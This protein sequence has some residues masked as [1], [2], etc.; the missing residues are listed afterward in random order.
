VYINAELIMEGNMKCSDFYSNCRRSLSIF[1]IL[2]AV[3]LCH[4]PSAS[5]MDYL[6]GV[7]GGYFVWDPFIKRIGV[8]QFEQ[9]DTGSG[10]L[11]GPVFSILFAADLSLSVSGLFG[12]Q[13]AYWTSIDYYEGSTNPRTGTFSLEMDRIDVDTALSYRLTENLKIFAGYKY[14]R[15][16]MTQEAVTY[17]RGSS[18]ITTRYENVEITM[19]VNGP[20]LGLGV[21][22]PL[23]ER[24][25]LAANLS[26]LYMIGKFDFK[27]YELEYQGSTP[28]VPSKDS[29]N[30]ITG[31]KLNIRGIN[32]EPTIGASM[33]DGMPIFTLGLRGQWSQTKIVDGDEI[34]DEEKWCNDY[35]YGIFVSI[36]QPL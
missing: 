32:F 4:I 31:I 25:F 34:V 30:K 33:G 21:S 2:S 1:I 10:V 22:A 12:T 35:Q 8:S 14:Q 13:S 29:T 26:A 23:G 36:V 20:A 28:A 7:K 19:P 6:F 3:M 5:S 15:S 17:E 24:Y 27:G 11:Y 16:V 9:I 18:D